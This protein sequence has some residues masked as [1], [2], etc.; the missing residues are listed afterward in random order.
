MSAVSGT[1]KFFFVIVV[2]LVLS[3]VLAP[4]VYE[5]L[6]FFKF[7]RILNRLVEIFAVIAAVLFV[8]FERASWRRYGVDFSTPWRRLFLYGF[9]TGALAITLLT[10]FEVAF[11]PRHLRYPILISDVIQRFLK[12][13]ISGVAVGIAEEFLFRG[14]I[15]V[16][17]ERKMTIAPAMVVTSV[18]YSSVHFLDNGQIFI[19]SK[20]I[21]GDSIRLLLGYLEPIVMRPRQIIPEFI[22]LFLFGLAL[23]T[24]FIR[25]RS[26]FLPIGIHAG[27]VFLIKF[28]NSFVRKGAEVSHFFF[29]KAPL[30]DGLTEWLFLLVLWLVVWFTPFSKRQPSKL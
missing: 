25:T 24:A 29:G 6:P 28:E 9:L 30:Y 22:G 16:S 13:T 2:I 19:P 18:L 7:G 15:F 23:N 3:I 4:T 20:P 8:R 27:A 11:G 5:L 21:V 17:L 10:T 26:L 12:G 1:L 14:F